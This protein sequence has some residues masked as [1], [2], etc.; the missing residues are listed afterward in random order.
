[1]VMPQ[2]ETG[3][4]VPDGNDDSPTPIA[5]VKQAGQR[6]AD[7][8]LRTQ[9]SDEDLCAAAQ[10]LDDVARALEDG[11]LDHAT[12]VKELRTWRRRPEHDPASGAR[13][14]IA[15]PLR[16]HGTGPRSML[17]EVTLG[18][19]YQ[20]PPGHAHGGISAMILDHALGVCNGWSGK[21]GVTGT[22]TLRYHQ[23]TPL[24][25]PLT[26]RTEC[27]SVEGRK[28]RTVGSIEY[29][30]ETCVSA[31]GLFIELKGLPG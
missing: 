5:L 4:V 18:Y 8:L 21:S 1:M 26:V 16:M 13:N 11:A 12:I 7:A 22:L 31:E 17:G 14:L 29:K 9:L 30:G 28:I 24:C 27:V 23:L 19:L 15:P 10:Q 2:A 3:F 20:G 25:V 6:V